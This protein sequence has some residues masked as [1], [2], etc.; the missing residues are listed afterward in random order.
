MHLATARPDLV[1][2]LLLPDPAVGQD[3]AW[4]RDIAERMFSSPNYT[5]RA[6][7]CAEK[8]T[9]FWADV[10]PAARDA[11]LD[12]HLIQLPNGRYR[13]RICVPAVLSYWSQ[14]A[15][16]VVYSPKGRPIVSA[17]LEHQPDQRGRARQTREGLGGR[18]W[19]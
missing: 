12:E 6:E 2:A 1:S 18:T 19:V 7:A 15:R 17:G 14:M 11:E 5:D 10:D 4:M 8:A 16:P 3:G 13:W 9:G